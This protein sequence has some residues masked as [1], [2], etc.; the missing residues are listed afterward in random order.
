MDPFPHLPDMM[1]SSPANPRIVE[2]RLAPR[3]QEPLATMPPSADESLTGAWAAALVED[4]PPEG[5]GT[6]GDAANSRL[7][8]MVRGGAGV[9]SRVQGHARPSEAFHM[10]DGCC[11][12]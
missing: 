7:G 3:F 10:R 1:T 6:G 2:P 9:I 5:T 12:E 11:S 8:P 4:A